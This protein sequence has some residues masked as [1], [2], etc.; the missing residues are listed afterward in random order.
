MKKIRKT[1]EKWDR[2]RGYTVFGYCAL[3]LKP[4]VSEQLIRQVMEESSG[5]DLMKNFRKRITQQPQYRRRIGRVAAYVT[6]SEQVKELDY[7]IPIYFL[8][9]K[10][11]K[12]LKKHPKDI[13]PK[14][15][16]HLVK[17]RRYS[18]TTGSIKNITQEKKDL[19]T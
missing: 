9:R 17:M 10:C 18:E 5:S 14:I 3:C 13:Y 12:R 2:F 11:T 15:E 8:C 6:D 4:L 16:E 1:L 7:R 19:F